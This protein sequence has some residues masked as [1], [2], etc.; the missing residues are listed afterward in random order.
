MG[1]EDVEEKVNDLCANTFLGDFL[2]GQVKV[3]EETSQSYTEIWALKIPV[4]IKYSLKKY[5]ELCANKCG[6]IR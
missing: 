1:R 6:Y 5:Y 2:V 3:K 4:S